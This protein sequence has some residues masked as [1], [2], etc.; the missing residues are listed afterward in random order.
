MMKTGQVMEGRIPRRDPDPASD[1]RHQH[2]VAPLQLL[3]P[4]GEEL[5]PHECGRCRPGLCTHGCGGWFCVPGR[6]C[7]RRSF[8]RRGRRPDGPRE[9]S[10]EFGCRRSDRGDHGVHDPA[11]RGRGRGDVETTRQKGHGRCAQADVGDR[12]DDSRHPPRLTPS[13]RASVVRGSR[14]GTR[15]ASSSP[16]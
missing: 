7:S 3:Q 11:P 1:P 12:S 13:H 4:A 15:T 10:H 9:T 5:R 6:V 8:A 2:D 14:S 16:P